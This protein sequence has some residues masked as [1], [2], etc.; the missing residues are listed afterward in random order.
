MHTF[1]HALCA[2][3]SRNGTREA[4][5]QECHR[6]FAVYSIRHTSSWLFTSYEV[7]LNAI[8]CMRGALRMPVAPCSC[9][10]GW[11]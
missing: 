11:V 7:L 2:K 4:R 6:T 8:C 1:V 3:F 9:T 5:I 10:A